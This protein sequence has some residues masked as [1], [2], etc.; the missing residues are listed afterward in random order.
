MTRRLAR[1]APSVAQTVDRNC[2]VPRA[3]AGLGLFG[4]ALGAAFAQEALDLADQVVAGRQP[5][6]VDHRLEPLDVRARRLLE[7][8]RGVEPGPELRAPPRRGRRSA[9]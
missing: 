5:L 9:G 8:G 6:L 7:R 3:D 1:I 2:H 4:R